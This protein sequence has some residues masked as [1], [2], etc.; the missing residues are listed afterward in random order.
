M[1]SGHCK[2][3]ARQAESQLVTIQPLHF[4]VA[5]PPFKELL[6]WLSMRLINT[7]MHKIGKFTDRHVPPYA[8][9]SD[10]GEAWGSYLPGLRQRH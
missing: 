7:I 10:R 5:F 4:D 6:G 9:L 3:P 2:R 8:L 1:A